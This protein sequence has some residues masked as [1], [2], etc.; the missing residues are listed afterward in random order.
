MKTIEGIA[1][2]VLF[3]SPI[4]ADFSYEVTRHGDAQKVVTKH[5]L[6]GERMVVDNG[7]TATVFDLGAKTVTTIDRVRKT[8]MVRSF[9]Q[10]RSMAA[11]SAGGQAMVDVKETGQTK[12]IAGFGARQIMM[13]VH[14]DAPGGQP[15]STIETEVEMW[16]SDEVPGANELR[17]FYVRNADAF[18]WAALSD[19]SGA[20]AESMA[21][22]QRKIA[23]IGGVPMLAITRRKM[24]GGPEP[25]P[26]QKKQLES[27][28]AKLQAMA[29][30]GGQ[31]GLAAQDALRRLAAESAPQPDEVTE[32]SGFSISAIPAS[33]FGVP[34]GF[35][36]GQ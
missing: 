36:P 24:I 7:E 13:T 16:V 11:Q 26:T 33:V 3:A 19:A 29:A 9:A 31:Q 25:S 5:Y 18:P 12:T 27:A 32:S 4:Y 30:S 23:K 34:A 21:N 22:A 35:A 1:V 17:A 2:A 28:R 6:R 14:V 8:Y 20:A 10:M 15:G